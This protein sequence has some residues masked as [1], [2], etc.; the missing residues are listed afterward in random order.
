MRKTLSVC[1]IVKNEANQIADTLENITILADEIVVV[2]TGSSDGTPNLVRNWAIA[3]KAT[4]AVKVIEVGSKFHDSDGD[5]DFGAAKT[6]AFEHA[7]KDYVMWLDASDKV[8]EQILLKKKFIEVT[9]NKEVII[10]IPTQTSKKH[11]F[12]RLRIAPRT[13]VKMIGKI[14]EYMWIE[15]LSGMSRIHLNVPILN[16]KPKRDLSRNVRILHKEWDVNPTARNAFYLGNTYYG[17]EKYDSAIEWFRKRVYN[18][19]WADEYAEEYFKSLECIADCTLKLLSRNKINGVRINLE[20]VYDVTNEMISREPL[21]I[22][23]Y[24]YKALYHIERIEYKQ[25]ID[26]LGNYSKCRIPIDVKLWLDPVIYNGET[27][28]RLMQK[29]KLGERIQ[30]PLIPDEI[31][32]YGG[33]G[34]GEYRKG[35]D[36]YEIGG[37]QTIF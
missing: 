26:A 35:N 9:E 23:G 25:A 2:D 31:L 24:Y 16:E 34:K 22:E 4:K 27:I 37:S 36:Q 17:L 5:F 10:T 14:H 11:S 7:T 3:K 19:E 28:K 8:Q 1:I 33:D 12:N 18:F 32:D 20:D 13:K 6:H 30:S 15:D 21:R 29:C